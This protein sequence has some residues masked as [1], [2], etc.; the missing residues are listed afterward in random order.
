MAYLALAMKPMEL[1]RLL[2]VVD[3]LMYKYLYGN[4][5]VAK[6]ELKEIKKRV[7]F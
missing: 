3:G 6:Y 5:L 4:L 1:L 7:K 2:T